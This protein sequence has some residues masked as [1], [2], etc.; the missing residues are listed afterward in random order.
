MKSLDLS[1]VD[2]QWQA[3]DNRNDPP[4]ALNLEEI[5]MSEEELI[6]SYDPEN[7]ENNY[8]LPPHLYK[9]LKLK[10]F[11]Q[12]CSEIIQGSLYLSS[13]Q[14][15]SDFEALRANRITHIV[16][17]AADVCDSRFPEHFQYL[18]YY[19][20][21]TNSEDI[22]LIFYRTLEWIQ[23]AIEQGGRVLV[24]CREGISRSASVVIAYLM[25]RCSLPFKVAYEKVSKIRPI[26]SPN[27][28]FTCQ[29]L[30]FGKKLGL[31]ESTQNSVL[32]E[33]PCLFRVAPYHPKEPF[34]L[35]MPTQWPSSW[36][37]FDSRLGWVIQ[38]GLQIV[39]W[40]GQE[41]ADPDAVQAAVQQHVRWMHMFERLHCTMSVVQEQQETLQLWQALGLPIEPGDGNG[42]ASRRSTYDAEVEVL[43]AAAAAAAAAKKVARA[44]PLAAAVCLGDVEQ[45]DD[46]SLSSPASEP[47]EFAAVSPRELLS[48][49]NPRTPNSDKASVS[50]VVGY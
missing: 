36:P 35:L 32:A 33:A 2:Q 49:P 20:K 26:C 8:H 16:N 25:W 18:T 15:A 47:S 39:L 5:N 42:L 3:T 4:V 1:P 50:T 30:R 11:R 21:D 41:V 27:T 9:Q 22:S 44:D 37:L 28:G 43:Q 29:L 48:S 12:V 6:S 24:H 40:L 46:S 45:D 7:E 13:Y 34:L 23:S 14:I 19:L 31:G 17:T 10:Q 38:R